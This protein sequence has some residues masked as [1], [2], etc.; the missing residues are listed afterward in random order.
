MGKELSRCAGR[1]FNGFIPRME[2]L[3]RQPGLPTQTGKID[4]TSIY[5]LRH[6]LLRRTAAET[7]IPI[8]NKSSFSKLPRWA[9]DDVYHFDAPP[10]PTVST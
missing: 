6:A 8:M 3:N 9:F 7:P 1:L 5:S 2:Q 10:R 4:E